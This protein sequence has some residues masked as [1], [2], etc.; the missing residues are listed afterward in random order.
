MPPLLRHNISHRVKVL[1]QPT[2]KERELC[3]WMGEMDSRKRWGRRREGGIM[4]E[5][6]REED[7]GQ[8]GQMLPLYLVGAAADYPG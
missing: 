8:T 7:L 6:T 2:E 5:H 4:E 1:W 3:V